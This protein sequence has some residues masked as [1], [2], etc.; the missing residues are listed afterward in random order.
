MLRD[1]IWEKS[2]VKFQIPNLKILRLFVL[3]FTLNARDSSA[4]QSLPQATGKGFLGKIGM[5]ERG[6]FGRNDRGEGC[7]MRRREG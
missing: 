1:R 3:T 7:G 2:K 5:T 6:V 4:R